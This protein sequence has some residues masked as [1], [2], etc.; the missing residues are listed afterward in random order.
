MALGGLLVPTKPSDDDFYN[1]PDG[2]ENAKLGDILKHRPVPH[3]VRSIYFPVNVQNSWQLLVRSEDVNGVPLAVVTTIFEPYNGNSSRLVAYDVAMDSAEVDCSPSYVFQDGGGFLTSNNQVEMF[4]IQGALDQGHYVVSTDYETSL[5]AF[6]VASLAGQSTLNAIRAAL[7][8]KDITNIEPNAEVITWGYS[9]GSFPSSWSAGLQPKYA[10][11]L[12]PNFKAAV[13][14]GWVVNISAVAESIEGGP[15]S[16]L[17]FAAINGLSH[18]YN[19]LYSVIDQK[20]YSYKEHDFYKANSTCLPL[21]IVEYLF[22]RV[23]SGPF[24]YAE[25]GWGI[26]QDKVVKSVLQDL[27]LGTDFTKDVKAEVPVFLYQGQL[28]EVAPFSEADRVYD[29]W[30]GQGMDSFEFAASQATGHIGEAV[31]G[32][33]A[34]LG[35]INKIFDGEEPVKGCQKTVRF[36]NLEHPDAIPGFTDALVGIVKNAFGIEIGPNKKD[37]DLLLGGLKHLGVQYDTSE[38]K[39]NHT[40]LD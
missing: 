4:L 15:F 10:P 17:T 28:D 2:F 7:Q 35:W 40:I 19:D 12:K 11:D 22:Q 33:G 26:L 37:S 1:A 3:K 9:G 16:G 5:A 21:T 20:I 27:T 8:S 39:A 32:S 29:N 24:K 13:Y 38:Q 25:D 34:A 14:G 30:C 18:Q 36:T 6:T 31:L 23:F